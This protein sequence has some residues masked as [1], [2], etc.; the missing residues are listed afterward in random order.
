MAL[1]FGLTTDGFNTQY[2]PLAAIFWHYRQEQTLKS[3]EQVQI[4]MKKRD[5]TPVDKLTQVLISVLVGCETLSEVNSKLKAENL[6]AKVCGWPRFADHSLLS[7]VL[8]ALTL[9]HLGQLQGATTE[10]WR[11]HSLV[12]EHDWRAYLWLDFDLSG[13]PCSAQAEASQKGYFSGKKTSLVAN[14]RV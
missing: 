8:D 3:L 12:M 14:L 5:F 2:A 7:R 1:E 11:A 6:V 9:K 4:D 13:L 10:I